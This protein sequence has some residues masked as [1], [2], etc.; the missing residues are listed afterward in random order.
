M[1][2]SQIRRSFLAFMLVCIL[3]LGVILFL[4]HQ[5]EA[6]AAAPLKGYVDIVAYCP[7]V[8]KADALKQTLETD[9]ATVSTTSVK[10]G[11][12]VPNGYRVIVR[13][14]KS[15][16]DAFQASMKV[17]HLPCAFVENKQALQFAGIFKTEKEAK[18]KAAS[19]QK[20]VGVAFKVEQNTKQVMKPCV[21]FIITNAPKDKEEKI[22]NTMKEV[23]CIDINIK[24]VPEN[25]ADSIEA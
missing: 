5:E 17:R 8:H 15:M 10:Y 9:G 12:P 18:A 3:C 4:I 19:V 23:G 24:D 25:A 14:D 7:K 11:V 1:T 21:K 6:I 16:L 22:T 13:A 20:Q 2:L